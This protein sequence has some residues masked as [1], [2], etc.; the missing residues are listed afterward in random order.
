MAKMSYPVLSNL[1]H[2]GQEYAP[3][4]KNNAVV[5]D[6][7]AADGLIAAGVLGEGA[8]LDGLTPAEALAAIIPTLQVGDFTRAGILTAEARRRLH[9]ELGFEPDETELR[10]AFEAYAK[11]KEGAA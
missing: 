6:E 11:A 8:P 3:G 10:T 2:D 4:T 5:M 9:A 1:L 7:R